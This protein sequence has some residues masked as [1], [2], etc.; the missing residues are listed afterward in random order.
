M[1]ALENAIRNACDLQESLNCKIIIDEDGESRYE[2]TK[3]AVP[4]TIVYE[5]WGTIAIK[6]ARI[7]MRIDSVFPYS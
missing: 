2:K 1:Q 5:E 4:I 3:V 6:Q 7:R